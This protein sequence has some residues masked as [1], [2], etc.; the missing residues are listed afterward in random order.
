M[1][2]RKILVTGAA[3]F[4][5]SHL[6]EALLK[7]GDDVVGIDNLNDYYPVAFKRENV[8]SLKAYKSF[9]FIEGELCDKALVDRVV[10]EG[11][12]T[13]VAHLAA[14]AGVRPSIQDPALYQRANIE[15]TLNLLQASVG[16]GIEN[17]VVTSSSSVYGNSRAVPF[18]EDDTATDRPISPYAATKKATEVLAYTYHSLHGVNINIVRPFTVYGPRGRPDMAPWLFIEAALRGTPIKKFG[19]GTTRRDYTFINDFVAGFVN[20]VDRVFGYE[21]F[22]LGN[23]Q[24]VSLNEALQIVKDVTGRGL[25]IEQLPM[26]PGDVEVTNA[27]IS[28]AK[29]LLDYN[30]STSFRDGMGALHEW[31]RSSRMNS[32]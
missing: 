23:S 6:A 21:I 25:I 17:I 8:N 19:D 7:R 18:R 29:R 27:D 28:K 31:Y 20:A 26:Q 15:A 16:K 4:I 11:S 9:S 22:N 13:H 30:P 12:F 5:G 1:S 14:R 24:T 3:G 2:T 10:S 32:R